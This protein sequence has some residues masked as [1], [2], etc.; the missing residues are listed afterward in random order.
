MYIG[1]WVDSGT[2][3]NYDGY[4]AQYTCIDGLELGPGYFAYTDPLTGAW[5]PKK[6]VAE[7]TT[8]NDGTNW[9]S[10]VSNA[11]NPAAN[12]FD[13]STSTY[14]EGNTNG[15]PVTWSGNVSGSKIE[16]Y[17]IQAGSSR[18][19]TVN[20]VDRLD[21]VPT[22]AGWFTI[23]DLTTLTAFTF[24]RGGSGNYVDV[25]AVRV[26]GV[27][28]TNNTTQNLAFGSAGFYLPLDG[29]TPIGEDLSGNNN[30]WRPEGFGGSVALDHPTVSG[31]RPI[32]NTVNGGTSAAPGVFGSKVS[33]TIAVTVSNATGNNKYYF[34]TVLNPTLALI[35]G[36][37]IT[38]DTTDSSN[39][40]H[41][42][43]LSSTNADSSSG[44][45][46]TD[47]V[48]YYINGSTVSGSDYV[49]NYNNNGGGTGF[50]GIKWTIPHNVSTTYYYCTSHTGMG[51]N[52]RLNSTTDETKADPYA[53]KCV[54]AMPLVGSNAD[55][56]DQ[57]NCTTTAKTLAPQGDVTQSSGQSNW[58]G[59]S[60]YFDGSGDYLGATS[61][62][63][64]AMG[65]GDFTLE[66]WVYKS[67]S[68]A[69]MNFMATRGGPGTSAGFTFGSQSS[70]N[71]YDVEFYTDGLKLDGGDQ[72][73]TDG[74]WHHVA[75]TR[76]GTSL[77]SY[78]NG[79]LNTTAT[80]SQN[81]SNTSLALGITNDATQGPL[82]GYLQD[83]RIYKGVAKYSG[84]SVGDQVFIVPATEPNIIP[85]SPSGVTTKS[86]L[87]KITDGAVSFDGISGTD[88]DYLS[89]PVSS[90]DFTFGTG[91]FTVEMFL[92]NKETAGKGFIQISD[93]AGGLKATSTGVITIHKA[94]GQNGAFRAYAKNT[95]TGFSTPVPYERWC[96]VALVR[97]SGTIKLFV[98]GKQDATTI[99]NDTTDYATTYVAIGGY[100]DTDY[101][102]KCIISNVRVNKGTALYTSDF[103]PPSEPLTNVTNT[104]LL[105]CQSNTEPGRA[106]VSPSISGIN[107][108]INWSHYVTGDIDDSFPAW[109]A[110]RNDT[111]SVGCRTQTAN[112]ATI[113]WQPPSP[114]AFSSSFK[115]WAARDGASGGTFTVTHAGGTTDFT[116]SVVTSTTQ[117]VVD[118]AQI[119]G[120]TSPITKITIVSGGPNPRFSGIEVDSVML[121]DPISPR[122]HTPAITLNPFNTDINTVRGQ[123]GIFATLNG[124]DHRS[125]TNGPTYTISNGALT[126]YMVGGNTNAS[127]DRGLVASTM[128]LP[129]GKKWYCEV[130]TENMD[131]NDVA[132]GLASELVKGYYELGGNSKPGAYL[133]RQNGIFYYPTGQLGSSSSRQYDSGDYVGIAVDLESS[134]K[135]ITF[136]KNGAVLYSHT[137]DE[138][139]GPFKF[140]AGTDAGSSS[141]YTYTFHFN[142]G[143]KPFKF[144]PPDGYQPLSAS[145]TRPDTV[146]TRPDKFV[147]ATTYTG[148]G[149]SSPGGS[150]GTQTISVGHKPDLIWIKDRTQ[151]HNNNLIDSVNGAPNLLMSDLTN[152]LDT[153]STDGVTAIT[154]TGFTLGDNGAGTQS[155][156]MNKNGNDYVAWTWKAGGG[157]VSGGGFFKDDVEYAS[158]AAAGLTAGTIT[159]DAASVGT[160]QGFSIIKYSLS[161]S[162]A[163]TIPHGL[164]G[165]LG[166]LIT[167]ATTTS[168]GWAVWHSSIGDTEGLVISGTNAASSVTWWDQSN[169]TN[170][171]FAHKAG[172]TSQSG[173]PIIAYCWHDVPGLQKFGK[174]TGNSNSNGPAID[175]GFRPALILLKKI[176]STD[177][178]S[179]WHWYD[180][181]RNTYNPANN[182]LLASAGYYENRAQ[183]NTADV[184]SY[185]VDFLSNGFRLSHGS[186]N[187]NSSG[188]TYIY[189]A[190]AEAPAFNL[191]GGQSNAR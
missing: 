100:F 102:S 110:F 63:D 184:S 6:F 75:V 168:N 56:C 112:G 157:K 34:D 123:E 141:G 147:S 160:K 80:N 78:V 47:G 99:T 51:N 175:L 155:L 152:G 39:N 113:V 84:G 153:T 10:S 77:R 124:K 165:S 180:N 91:D 62:A 167:K 172:T 40:S 163:Q 30:D 166:L 15:T 52:G 55:V 103:T 54:L 182:F 120:V 1:K 9:S 171:V 181:K 43:K 65:T 27:I 96:H 170:N 7:G 109:R 25:F 173:A 21:L 140:A 149:A 106:A 183:N 162:S 79:V 119:G 176:T 101:L 137:V 117:T 179:G 151:A 19:F 116:S 174:Y 86:K 68:G 127:K 132:L 122:G 49:S 29:N 115:I 73:I 57:I 20:G 28:M 143:Q 46:Y 131:N 142:F 105:G 45:E 72:G 4:L 164:D 3:H 35:R 76:S 93:T 82:H 107:D 134:T 70:G 50:R 139:Q 41:P 67:S 121:L 85:D 154:D 150:G 135:N 32:L 148:N 71:G 186:N 33:S 11:A 5:R 92:Y 108:G 14:T 36:A 60:Y 133:L 58:Y 26:D 129:S 81:L 104:K 97:Q 178:N 61:N 188:A 161:G 111:T 64:F 190:W 98:D 146:I 66:C 118:L 23:P 12:L 87:K 189:A 8:V 138:G 16:F 130:H 90:S 83:V 48:A 24:S 31:A 114:I 177:S 17:A 22:S 126:G 94:N 88:G 156:E 158:A 125:F 159:P 59:G 89:T 144:P 136:Y 38:F 37:T 13:G 69:F 2:A 145:T 187:L 42:F 53:W 169:M 44:T 185:T 74:R 128:D 18:T 191:F 95:S